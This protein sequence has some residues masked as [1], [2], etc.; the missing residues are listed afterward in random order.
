MP[1]SYKKEHPQEQY[2]WI[3]IGSGLSGISLAAILSKEGKKCLVLER[4]YTAGGYTHVFK[5]RDYEWDVGIHYVGEVHRKEKMLARLFRYITDGQLEWE[6]M[7]EV[8]DQIIFGKERFNYVK[9]TENF[10]EHLKTYFPD[11]EDQAAIDKYVAM[12]RAASHA[13]K[14]LFSKRALPPLANRLFGNFISR[15]ANSYSRKTTREVLETIT[16]NEKLIGVLTGQYG[17]YGMPPAQSSFIMHALLAKHYLGGGSFPIGGSARIFETVEPV[18]EK[19]GGKVFT[20]ASVE[21][22]IVKNGKAVGVKMSDGKEILAPKVAS[23][24]GVHNTYLGLLKD[25]PKIDKFKQQLEGTEASSAHLC[26]YVGMKYT[27]KELNINKT[28]LWIYPDNFNHD[29]NMANY[30]ADPDNAEFPLVYISFPSVKDPDWENRY[31]GKST[32]EIITLGD[33]GTFKKWEDSRWKKR[34]EDYDAYKEKISQRLLQV[35]F[36][37][38]PQLEGKI[39]YYE[40]STPLSTK[41]FVNYQKGEIYGLVH[42]PER[43]EQ[44]MLNVH[45]PIKNLYLTGQD[46]VTCGIGGA[47]S[48]S[49]ITAMGA[50]KKNIMKKI[51][52]A[53]N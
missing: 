49:M 53:T 14:D 2:D 45:T 5:R 17:D 15:K 40:L 11:P 4:H 28:N 22:I 13:S 24:I 23:S 26:L 52:E 16:K 6:E 27:A 47:L 20:N 10:K 32:L 50:T 43:F 37:Y 51:I 3:I 31:P 19:S 41:H 39:D 29:E 46:I 18:I 21:K 38:L 1:A 7:D 35:L 33:Y 8:Y 36:K 44:S 42:T 48:A 12:I 9:G 25:E 34:G 30:L